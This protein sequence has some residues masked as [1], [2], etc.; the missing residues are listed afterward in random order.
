MKFPY[1]SL[2]RP[3]MSALHQLWSVV[4]FSMTETK[5]YLKMVQEFLKLTKYVNILS[6]PMEGANSVQ[7][8]TT[9]AK[10]R[11]KF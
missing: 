4:V 11:K 6:F 3:T 7:T 9:M 8:T 2:L 1:W 5:K 10:F